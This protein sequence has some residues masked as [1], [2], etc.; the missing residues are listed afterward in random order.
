[1]NNFNFK[2]LMKRTCALVASTN[3]QM[4]WIV[5]GFSLKNKFTSFLF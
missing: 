2:M 3:V 4:E 5:F 1:M